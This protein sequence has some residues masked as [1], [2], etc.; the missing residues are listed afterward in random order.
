MKFFSASAK[1]TWEADRMTR[2]AG[3]T[4]AKT[5][6]ARR[7]KTDKRKNIMVP[8]VLFGCVYWHDRSKRV[9]MKG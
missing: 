8:V 5:D 1:T 7:A 3:G 6:A 4:K 9:L 2:G